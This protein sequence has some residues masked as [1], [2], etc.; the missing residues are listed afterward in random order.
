MNK[1]LFSLFF[2]IS[3]IGSASA[4]GGEVKVGAI[5]PLNGTIS[6]YGRD[7]LLGIKMAI[8]EVNAKEEKISFIV[9]DNYGE[10]NETISKFKELVDEGV[11]L[12]IGPII[13]SNVIAIAPYTE[14]FNIPMIVPSATSPVVTKAS[15]LIFRLCYTDEFQGEA[16]ARFIHHIIGK[17]MPAILIDESQIYSIGL[18]KSFKKYVEKLGLQVVAEEYYNSTVFDF[19]P[20]L[21]AIMEKK[22]DCI[23]VPGYYQEASVIINQ[24]RGLGIDIPFLGGD[25]WDSPRLL[26]YTGRVTGTNFYCV[27]F[28]SKDPGVATFRNNYIDRFVL[29]PTSFSALGYDGIKLIDYLE[30]KD[31]TP[32]AIIQALSEVSNFK[33]ITGILDFTKGRDPRKNVLIV[34][35]EDG[36]LSLEQKIDPGI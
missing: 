29:E 12:I 34:R 6:S 31:T 4:L 9:K 27:H 19:K 20:Q 26:N 2:F 21:L 30:L 11:N 32:T 35:M 8:D 13:S 25:G 1:F 5:L 17:R 15:K 7:C 3:T 28:Y 16:I 33:G 22:P 24:A 23:F 36:I 10:E 18:A 14:R